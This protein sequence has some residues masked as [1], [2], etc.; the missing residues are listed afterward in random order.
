ML[1]GVAEKTTSGLSRLGGTEQWLGLLTTSEKAAPRILSLLIL[2]L[3]EP[4]EEATA[5]SASCSCRSRL[6]KQA[7]CSLSGWLGAKEATYICSGWLCA[8]SCTGSLSWCSKQ[9]AASSRWLVSEE[10]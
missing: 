1:V 7:A 9:R 10:A 5:T 2:G 3:P 8:E 6:A 4:T